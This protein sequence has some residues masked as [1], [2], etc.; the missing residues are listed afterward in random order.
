MI[1][2]VENYYLVSF[3]IF[4]WEFLLIFIVIALL[5]IPITLI[6]KIR[7][8]FV[9]AIGTDRTLAGTE[10]DDF[11]EFCGKYECYRQAVKVNDSD[12]YLA[13]GKGQQT[14]RYVADSRDNVLFLVS[15][16]EEGEDSTL[17]L[18]TDTGEERSAE[19]TGPALEAY[20]DQLNVIDSRPLDTTGAKA[21]WAIN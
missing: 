19:I 16:I 18:T 6:P 5:I 17:R 10:A 7:D 8:T 14:P 1:G 20:D 3:S 12:Y 15:K 9:K 2:S 11:V 4:S 13:W 21:Y